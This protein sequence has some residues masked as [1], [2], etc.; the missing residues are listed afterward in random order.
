MRNNRLRLALVIPAGVPM[1]AVNEQIKTPVLSP[2]KTSKA[3][4]L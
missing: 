4:P 2:D 3:L 1:T